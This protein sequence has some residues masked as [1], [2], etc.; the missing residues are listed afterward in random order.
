M[1]AGPGID[2]CILTFMGTVTTSSLVLSA[3]HAHR[4]D[5][6]RFIRMEKRKINP[7]QPFLGAKGE[8]EM[9]D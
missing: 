5:L 7:L 6:V 1:E 2:A 3:D 9:S 8:E 4:K